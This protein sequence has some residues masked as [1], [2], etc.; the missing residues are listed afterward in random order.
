MTTSIANVKSDSTTLVLFAQKFHNG[1]YI[2]NR[3]R[4]IQQ[5]KKNKKLI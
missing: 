3:Y 1:I 4:F 2:V 5:T